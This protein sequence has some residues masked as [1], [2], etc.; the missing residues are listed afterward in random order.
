VD[1]R[2]KIKTRKHRLLRCLPFSGKH[3]GFTLTEVVVASALLVTAIVPILRAL[4]NVHSSGMK[5]EQKT[6]SLVLSQTKLEEIKAESI[7][8]YTTI[9][10]E[11]NTVLEGSYLC[12]VTDAVVT[13]NLRTMSVA[14]GFDANGNNTLTNDEVLVTL[15]TLIARRW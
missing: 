13:A 7:Y 6:R 11:N 14:V 3:R 2:Q 8:N 10:T 1:S 4:T 12:N 5:I 9:F 15:N